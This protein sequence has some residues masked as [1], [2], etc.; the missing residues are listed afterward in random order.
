MNINFEQIRPFK[1][2][3]KNTE[4]NCSGIY[5]WGFK[6]TPNSEFLPYYVGIAD[7][8]TI[9]DRLKHHYDFLD[10]TYK[11]F[12]SEY[13]NSFFEYLDNSAEPNVIEKHKDKLIYENKKDGVRSRDVSEAY[14]HIDFYR[15]HFYY[16]YA[17]V[18]FKT[19]Q[20]KQLEFLET[21]IKYSLQNQTVGKSLQLNG[22]AYKERNIANVILISNELKF[23]NS[24]SL[25]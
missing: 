4:T 25:F 13:L 24:P 3:V 18:E 15:K 21:Y 19:D 12:N 8:I 16:S 2:L 10:T 7:R 1:E 5:I 17:R 14:K 23:K 20:K 9:Y 11:I 22:K 6:F